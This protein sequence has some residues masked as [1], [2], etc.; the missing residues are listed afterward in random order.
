MDAYHAPFVFKHRYWI[1]ILLFTRI[2]HH[3]LSSILDESIHPL[4]V[5]CLMCVLLIIK[6]W[7]GEVYKNWLISFFET[8]FLINLLL[9]SVS[10]YYVSNTNGDQ[11][12]LANFSVGIAFVAFSG[13]VLFH[14]YK[15]ILKNLRGYA[16][17]ILSLKTCLQRFKAKLTGRNGTTENASNEVVLEL[18][19]NPSTLHTH[20]L[21]EPLLD[22]VGSLSAQD[23]ALHAVPSAAS[24]SPHPVTCT[25]VSINRCE[26]SDED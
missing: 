11:G 12:A 23:R 13:I 10:T 26:G 14:T 18:N 21:R 17:M 6:I 3:F 1:G 8:S 24:P 22:D 2:I 5:S 19:S 25:V 9:F 4:I 20:L 7:I 16:T 15:Y